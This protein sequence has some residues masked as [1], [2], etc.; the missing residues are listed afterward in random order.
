MNP[1][2]CKLTV[3]CMVNLYQDFWASHSAELNVV[4][5]PSVF[6][7]IITITYFPSLNFLHIWRS[8]DVISN[9][10]CS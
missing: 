8:V 5:H 3:L 9:S 4:R 6:L 10:Q 1:R 7:P 2:N